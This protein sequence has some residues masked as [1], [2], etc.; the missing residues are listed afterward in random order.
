MQDPTEIAE[1]RITCPAGGDIPVTPNV[2]AVAQN[3]PQQ[4]VSRPW[5]G[6]QPDIMVLFRSGLHAKLCNNCY[7]SP[8]GSSISVEAGLVIEPEQ[9]IEGKQLNMHLPSTY[10]EAMSDNAVVCLVD[11]RKGQILQARLGNAPNEISPLGG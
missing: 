11:R 3:D 1:F 10:I 5:I 6:R 4:R 2:K 8:Q 9:S 7:P